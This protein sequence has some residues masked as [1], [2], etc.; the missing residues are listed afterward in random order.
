MY[1][2]IGLVLA[3]LVIKAICLLEKSGVIVNGVVSNGATTN[4]KLWS[5]LGV[6]GEKGKITNT[7]K[8]PLNNKK[9]IYMISDAPQLI[10]NI[11]NRLFNKKGLRVIKKIYFKY[12]FVI[13]ICNFTGITRFQ[14]Y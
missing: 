11:R 7:F 1:I 12:L 4:R 6:T 3:Q 5:E 14:L 13:K 8:H 2:T 10:K 9:S